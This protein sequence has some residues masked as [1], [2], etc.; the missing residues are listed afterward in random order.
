MLSKTH[1]AEEEFAKN[2]LIGI[3]GSSY[4]RGLE[5]AYQA[6][7]PP[8][9]DPRTRSHNPNRIQSDL[10]TITNLETPKLGVSTNQQMM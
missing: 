10:P 3:N 6:L 5:A 7:I 2:A 4:E 9:S 8:T 1:N